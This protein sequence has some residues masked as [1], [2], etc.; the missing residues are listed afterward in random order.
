VLHD[1]FFK[2]TIICAYWYLEEIPAPGAVQPVN[3]MG[4]DRDMAARKPLLECT[5]YEMTPQNV[6]AL[7]GEKRL[8]CVS[9]LLARSSH[10]Q[11]PLGAPDCN[12]RM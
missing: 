10:V 3:K 6:R 2:L 7:D 5:E 11:Q 8:W 12:S 4:V 1:T 9:D